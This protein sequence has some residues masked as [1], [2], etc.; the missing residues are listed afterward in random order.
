[1]IAQCCNMEVDELIFNGG[2]CHVYENQ[3]EKYQ[4][5]QSFRNPHRYALP[6]LWLHPEITD[7]NQF[8]FD[9]IQIVGYKSYPSIKY[10]LSVGLK[11]K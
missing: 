11:I 9:D 7:I 5:E 3:I 2:D 10:P 8:T 4:K 6:K 1:M